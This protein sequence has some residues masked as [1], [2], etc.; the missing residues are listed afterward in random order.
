MCLS[1]LNL[2]FYNGK[3]GFILTGK[4]ADLKIL[5]KI[6]NRWLESF[7]QDSPGF[8]VE[9]GGDCKDMR[10]ESPQKAVKIWS[11]LQK[12]DTILRACPT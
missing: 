9:G 11:K 12:M 10:N 3:I 7:P 5:N 8:E 6:L 2:T 4:S 1:T